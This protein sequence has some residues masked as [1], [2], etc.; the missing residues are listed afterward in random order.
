MLQ[1]IHRPFVARPGWVTVDGV[2]LRVLT[3]GPAAAPPVLLVHGLGMSAAYW[4]AHTFPALAAAFR[5]IAPDLPG[6][7]RSAPL[8][9]H[10]LDGY[11]RALH[12]LLARLAPDTPV[13]V[14]G[15]SMGGQISIGLAATHP[16]QVRS[17]TLVGAAGMP[18]RE[19]PWRVVLRAARDGCNYQPRLLAYGWQAR[20]PARVYRECVRMIMRDGAQ[21][22]ALL[23]RITAP[24]LLV[25][26]E[27]DYQVPL[28]YGRAMAHLL[29]NARL[30]VGRGLGHVPFF[31]RPAAFHRLVAA[32]LAAH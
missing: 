19:P 20:P 30:A 17:L 15:H 2:R 3:A 18:W 5:L 10:T 29:P 24:V 26:G 13:H 21:A 31:E 7:G 16:A 32:F 1:R 6:F 4:T 23:P 22:P 28:A 11:I 12:G 25:W 8:A 14:L 27:R 9:R